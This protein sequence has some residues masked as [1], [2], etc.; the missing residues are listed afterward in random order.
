LEIPYAGGNSEGDFFI[1]T[2]LSGG[3]DLIRVNLRSSAVKNNIQKTLND[4]PGTSFF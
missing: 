2:I 3:K 4:E 1:P